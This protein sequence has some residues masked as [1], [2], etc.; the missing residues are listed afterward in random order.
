[1]QR[2]T[3][4]AKSKFPAP[5][6]P[7]AADVQRDDGRW[8]AVTSRDASKDGAFYFSVATTGIYCRPG[9]PAR[10][11]K[12]EN[13]TFYAT[14]DEA[15]AAGFR[16]CKRCK[17]REAGLR[18]T[19]RKIV[20]DA[21]RAIG[22]SAEPPSLADLA[23]S[24]GLSPHHF[25]RLFKSIVGVTP[26]AY[27]VAHR[28]KR[29]RD[30]L[31]RSKSVTD[32]I[33][34]SGF[35]SNGRFYAD[36]TKVLG[37]TPTD[38][39]DGGANAVIRYAV[40]DCALGKVLVAAS[41]AGVCAIYLGEDADALSAELSQRFPKA[42]VSGG[43]TKFDA[44]TKKVVRAVDAPEHGWDL[45]LDIRGTAFQHRVWQA[46]RDIPPGETRTY[47]QIAEAIGSPKAVRAVGTA[48][49]ANEISVAIPCHRVVRSDG[50]F[51]NANYRWGVDRKRKLLD[52]EAKA[53]SKTKSRAG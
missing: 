49:G 18:E 19:H 48:C 41:E 44:L 43:D 12:R 33:Y 4:S 21:C 11:P 25:H 13:V 26:K 31:K 53:R 38:Y 14:A 5:V 35:N 36:A 1:M 40:A 45:P 39:R 15:E 29:M 28:Q 47:A 20:A 24:A 42:I 37:M 52:R 6:K 7:S 27:A 23:R 46:L 51:P 8:D 30:T 9:C 10:T 34:D 17:P 50:S 16:A 2:S 32:A 3:N 22:M